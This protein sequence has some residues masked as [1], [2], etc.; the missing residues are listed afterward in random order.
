MQQN[1]S[2]NEEQTPVSDELST[3]S[4]AIRNCSSM[5]LWVVKFERPFRFFKILI[6]TIH[7][8]LKVDIWPLSRAK[9]EA[10]NPTASTRQE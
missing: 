8:M 1:V 7:R 2:G 10:D 4:L 9:H 5:Y 3:T 6:D